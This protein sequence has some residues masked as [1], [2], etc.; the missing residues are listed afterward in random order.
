MARNSRTFSDLDLNFIA[1]PVTGDISKKFDDNA[2]K[3]SI[4]NLVMTNHYEK[5][6]HPEIG[7]QVQSLLFEPFS[8]L[9]QAMLERAIV[10][11][12]SN[13]EPRVQLLGVT[14]KLNPNNHTVYVNIVFRI[15]NTERPL[16]VDLT[17]QR[18]R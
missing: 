12:I 14:V 11:T 15:I 7:S 6:F 4:K 18:T 17:L 5:P 8:P 2:I 1:N 10:N 9:L 16:T 13:F 3:Q